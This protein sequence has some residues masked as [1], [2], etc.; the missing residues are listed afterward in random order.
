VPY[1]RPLNVSTARD[2]IELSI[3]NQVPS[4]HLLFVIFAS[5]SFFVSE[6]ASHPDVKHHGRA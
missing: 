1:N 6:D 3:G 4:L 5:P 2:I